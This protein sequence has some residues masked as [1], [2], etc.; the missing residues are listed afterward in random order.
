MAVRKVEQE[1]E[2]LTALGEASEPEAI[3]G[4]AKSLGDHVNIIVAKS[5]RIAAARRFAS[6]TPHLL[7]AFDRLFQECHERDPQCWAKNAIAQA[8]VDLEYRE[9]APF[10]RGVRHVQMEPV[11]AGQEDTAPTLRSICALA[12]PACEGIDRGEVLRLLVEALSDR[13]DPVRV[14]A[15]RALGEMDGEE[16]VLLLRLKARLGDSSP[17]VTGQIFDT[18]LAL[19]GRDAVKFVAGFLDGAAEASAEAALSLGSSRLPEAVDSLIDCWERTHD[20][21]LRMATLRGLAVSR[22]E[23]AL[24]FLMKLIREGRTRDAVAAIDALSVARDA[25]E[26]RKRVEAAASVRE[27][28]VREALQKAFSMPA[29]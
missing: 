7:R 8:L 20:P 21:D 25:E 16:G 13:A 9:A 2:R 26:I 6:L 17:R 19:E 10:I 15:V 14:D 27:P 5:A 28:E 29:C 3:A 11:W 12:L 18:V 4:L 23:P 24:D 1:L 22:Q